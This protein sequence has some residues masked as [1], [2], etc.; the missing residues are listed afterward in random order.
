MLIPA[1]VEPTFTLE[2]TSSVS[3]R[4]VGIEQTS[5]R[6]LSVKPFWARAEK[7][8]MKLIP[9]AAAALSIARAMGL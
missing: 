8:P 3:E 6:S 5:L 4:E 9:T 2:Q 1:F 7:P